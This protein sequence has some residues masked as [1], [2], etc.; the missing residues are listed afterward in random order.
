MSSPDKRRRMYYRLPWLVSKF[1]LGSLLLPIYM[2]IT[3]LYPRINYGETLDPR[4]LPIV[5]FYSSMVSYMAFLG[6]LF[7]HAVEHSPHQTLS[8]PDCILLVYIVA[9]GAEELYQMKHQGLGYVTVTNICDLLM[10]MFFIAFF[11]FRVI[12]DAI[13]S[14][15]M[16]RVAEYV[17]AV[18]AAMSFLRLLYYIQVI[19]K[20]GPILFSFKAITTEVVS[21]MTILLV[22]FYAFG[23]AVTVVYK[24][25]IYTQE[26]QNGNISLPHL[27]RG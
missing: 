16:Y 26:F 12:G 8:W 21:F 11:I 17:F 22:M 18:L 15:V 20:L 27:V 6:L 13:D 9:M 25:G 7:A 4:R 14:L 5:T 3:A 19:R 23:I 2:L 1:L 24:A 10:V